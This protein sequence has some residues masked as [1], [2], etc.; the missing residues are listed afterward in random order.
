M[1]Y[2]VSIN[3]NLRKFASVYLTQD[4]KCYSDTKFDFSILIDQKF[5]LFIEK[6]L[7]NEI[8]WIKNPIFFAIWNKVV[9]IDFFLKFI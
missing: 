2:L 7:I 3:V 6:K 9:I 5:I 1:V 8:I 4:W